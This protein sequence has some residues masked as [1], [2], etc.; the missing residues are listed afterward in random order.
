MPNI[1]RCICCFH[2]LHKLHKTSSGK[3]LKFF[4]LSSMRI[5][6]PIQLVPATGTL[7]AQRKK[8]WE[9][10]YHPALIYEK[11]SRFC[12]DFKLMGNFKK[13]ND[14]YFMFFCLHWLHFK[15]MGNFKNTTDIHW[16][17]LIPQKNKTR[18]IFI[19]CS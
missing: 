15:L 2:H 14:I 10:N 8:K 7:V 16:L 19:S 1:Y 5:S 11:T 13:K 9:L 3:N 12:N 4:K 17:P 6:Y 18:L